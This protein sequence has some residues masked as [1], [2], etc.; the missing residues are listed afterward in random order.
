MNGAPMENTINHT[1]QANGYKTFL[2][3]LLKKI[4]KS[5]KRGNADQQ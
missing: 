2:E 5:K 1:H 4:R 3:R